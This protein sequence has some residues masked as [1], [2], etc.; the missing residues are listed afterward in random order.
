MLVIKEKEKPKEGRIQ[1]GFVKGEAGGM[2]PVHFQ[3]TFS[4]EIVFS[5]LNEFKLSYGCSKTLQLRKD[6]T[7]NTARSRNATYGYSAKFAFSQMQYTI[8]SITQK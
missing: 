6:E 3:T 8:S 7:C 1:R 5:C 2:I 4:D